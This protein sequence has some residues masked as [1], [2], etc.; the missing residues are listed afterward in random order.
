MLK[1]GVI[2]PLTS[3]YTFNII[4]VRKKDGAGEGMDRMCINY[5][6][7]NKV[8]EK[9]SEHNQGIFITLSWSK[10][11]D[12]TRLSIC[13]LANIINKKESK[14]YSISYCLWIVLIQSNAFW[15][16]KYPSNIPKAHE[17]C[18]ERLFKEV[19]SNIS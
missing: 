3:P 11:V 14:V 8:T 1:N 9:D 5:T 12:R 15:I 19:L 16:S 18:L 13:L 10:M 7:L 2:K 6:P 4:I 17:R